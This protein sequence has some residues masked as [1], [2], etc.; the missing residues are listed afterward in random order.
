ML[1]RVVRMYFKEENVQ[2]FL[3]IFNESKD[4]IRNFE[5]CLKLDLLQDINQEHILTT[6]SYWRDKKSLDNYRHSAFF[7]ENWAQMKKLFDHKPVAFS[8]I[9]L[10]EVEGEKKTKISE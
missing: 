9:K 8:C 7:M 5:G 1:I 2:D 3:E 6:Y 10:E 4:R